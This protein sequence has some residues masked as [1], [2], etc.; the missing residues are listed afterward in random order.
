MK[1][2]P[3]S[4]EGPKIAI[5]GAGCA[6]LTFAHLL[7]RNN[8]KNVKIFDRHRSAE[9]DF[10]TYHNFPAR[11]QTDG[12]I[13][14]LKACNDAQG[15]SALVLRHDIPCQLFDRLSKRLPRDRIN[16]KHSLQS[17]LPIFPSADAGLYWILK[18]AG[19]LGK[20]NK[21]RLATKIEN[22]LRI[23]TS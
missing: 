2:P 23:S 7:N 6:G 18:Q 13:A 21:W 8:F 3:S 9:D 20:P 11:L 19:T 17:L 15:D 22:T 12:R 16:W 1:A 5:V 4:A 10:Y 14:A